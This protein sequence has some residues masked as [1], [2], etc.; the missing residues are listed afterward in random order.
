VA[1]APG[2]RL[3]EEAAVEAAAGGGGLGEG[4]GDAVGRGMDGRG[5]RGYGD[6]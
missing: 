4:A 2:Q 1:G 6:G 3:G 5:M